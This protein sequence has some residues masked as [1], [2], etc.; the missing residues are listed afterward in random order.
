M[1]SLSGILIANFWTLLYAMRYFAFRWKI[2]IRNRVW[3]GRRVDGGVEGK[4]RG[5][6]G[7]GRD[8][9]GGEGQGRAGVRAGKEK[10]RRR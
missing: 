4:G 6:A 1:V 10:V 7:A 2:G 8:G 9:E 5:G 3:M